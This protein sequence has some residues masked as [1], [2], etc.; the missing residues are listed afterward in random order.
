MLIINH[1]F[2]PAHTP[3]CDLYQKI[4]SFI[5]EVTLLL[6]LHSPVSL[7]PSV[8]DGT[9][10][11]SYTHWAG[12][13]AVESWHVSFSKTVFN[14]NSPGFLL[15][16]AIII[17]ETSTDNPLGIILQS[18]KW[19]LLVTIQYIMA[20]VQIKSPIS[21]WLGFSAS[22]EVPSQ[23]NLSPTMIHN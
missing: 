11:S 4:S 19:K 17:F 1:C 8:R 3:T 10:A 13:E 2:I 22:L 12:M 6:L 5:A 15:F 18:L 9:W 14:T 16:L 20:N 7:P 21:H 23:V